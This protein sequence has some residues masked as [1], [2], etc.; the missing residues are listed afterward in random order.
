MSGADLARL[1]AMSLPEL[2]AA[3][4]ARWAEP[5]AYR[6]RDSLARAMAYRLQV[7]AAGGL[8][9]RV[10][11]ELQTLADKFAG[12]RQFDPGPNILLKSGSSL[13]REWGGK[14]HE[15]VVVEDGFMHQ[16]TRYP[17]LSQVAKAITGTKWNGPLFFGVKPRKP[18]TALARSA[19]A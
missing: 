9:L 1:G 8:P 14:R 16:G 3:W 12:D 10:K 19:R 11:R 5:P 18:P 6:S 4:T 13:I 15:V 2:R 17:S 7:E